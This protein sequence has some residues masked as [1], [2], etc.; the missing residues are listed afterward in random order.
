[1]LAAGS[2]T[3]FG[4]GQNKLLARW[5][6][7]S[8]IEHVLAT[9]V[10]ARTEGLLGPVVVVHSPAAPEVGAF[11]TEAECDAVMVTRE[12]PAIAESIKAGFVALEAVH[13]LRGVTA[14]L[15]I[16]GD[17]PRLS[18]DAIRALVNRGAG[19]PLVLARPRYAAAPE[20]PG[21]PVLLG[22]SHWPLVS[23]TEGDR[24][25]DR[26]VADRGLQ[27][28]RVDLPG[29]NPDVDTAADLDALDRDAGPSQA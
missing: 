25:L 2:G 12:R 6:G 5:R 15:L 24:G 28:D 17:Q 16:L 3:R 27:W 14:A 9:V 13:D 21:H 18:V 20:T 23:L 26:I 10:S 22:R 29:D 11:A 1:M 19:S 4:T 8:L 7:R